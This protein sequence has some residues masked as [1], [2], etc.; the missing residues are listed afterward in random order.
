[1]AQ[2]PRIETEDEKTIYS[3]YYRFMSQE[4]VRVKFLVPMKAGA[5]FPEPPD[6]AGSIT[7]KSGTEFALATMK[8]KYDRDAVI[9]Y[10]DWK[11]LRECYDGWECY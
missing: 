4:I 11:R 5:N 9:M 8:G 10:T 2:F 6:A 1:M 3:L 7:L